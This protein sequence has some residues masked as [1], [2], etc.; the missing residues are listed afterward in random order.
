[1]K[2]RGFKQDERD[3]CFFIN[4]VHNICISVLVDDILAV[5]PKDATRQFLQELAKEMELRWGMV[6][7]NQLHVRGCG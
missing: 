4:E 2:E 7:E 5:D 6:P 1:M 3:P